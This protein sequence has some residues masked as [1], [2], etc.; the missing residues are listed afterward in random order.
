MENNKRFIFFKP[1]GVLGKIKAALLLNEIDILVHKVLI[2]LLTA[3]LLISY[4]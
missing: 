2:F 1:V 3:L 4:S